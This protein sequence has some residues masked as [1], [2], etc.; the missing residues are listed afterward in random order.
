MR[1][2]G[3]YKMERKREERDRKGCRWERIG[4]GRKDKGKGEEMN[5]KR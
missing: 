1:G 3:Q 5:R 2:N 4:R